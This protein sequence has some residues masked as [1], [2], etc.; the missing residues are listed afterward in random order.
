VEIN[1]VGRYD[2][3]VG[4]ETRHQGHSDCDDSVGNE[5]RHQGH[6]DL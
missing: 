5:T 6:G 2:D 1:V 4:N 3:S